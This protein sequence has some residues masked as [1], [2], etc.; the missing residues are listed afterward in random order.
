LLIEN[1]PENQI[2]PKEEAIAVKLEQKKI[3]QSDTVVFTSKIIP[4]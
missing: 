1:P 3:N 2:I 4:K